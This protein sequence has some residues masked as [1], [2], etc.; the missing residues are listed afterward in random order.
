MRAGAIRLF[1][2]ALAACGGRVGSS[3]SDAGDAR[4]PLTLRFDPDVACVAQGSRI[5]VLVTVERDPNAAAKDVEIT[6]TRLPG[7]VS[8]EPLTIP[9]GRTSGLLYFDVGASTPG[10]AKISIDAN[11][12]KASFILWVGPQLGTPDVVSLSLSPGARD[13]IAVQGE[14]TIVGE[15]S[16]VPPNDNGVAPTT[17]L[18]RLRRDWTLDPTF[19]SSG[20]VVLGISGGSLATRADGSIVVGTSSLE[21]STPCSH[22]TVLSR[23]GSN[24]AAIPEPNNISCDRSDAVQTFVAPDQ[25]T[26]V[27]G[28]AWDCCGFLE[29]YTASGEVD[30]SFGHEG[31]VG[32]SDP[33]INSTYAC[34]LHGDRIALAGYHGLFEVDLRGHLA[35]SAKDDETGMDQFSAVGIGEDRTVYAGALGVLRAFEDDGSVDTAFGESG[36]LNIAGAPSAVLPRHD[37]IVL[38]TST[39]ITRLASDGTSAVVIGEGGGAAAQD[40][41]GRI[42]SSG[43]K[44]ADRYWP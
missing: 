43:P 25:S 5:G 29:R 30:T 40:S 24:P 20:S 8:V 37:G 26:Y 34:A 14:E 32:T 13:L 41:C 16:E 36:D 35:F 12:R 39:R 21:E 22:L 9:A 23:D 1:I 31:S 6:A 2:G 42:V 11:G 19:G 28:W 10:R 33:Y 15:T 18:V 27:C 38:V 44:E 4:V 3:P 17:T 7:G